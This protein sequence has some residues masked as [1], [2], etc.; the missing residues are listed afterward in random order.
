[1]VTINREAGV[2]FTDLGSTMELAA[3]EAVPLTESQRAFLTEIG[4]TTEE[5]AELDRVIREQALGAERDLAAESA[6]AYLA[7]Q[8]QRAGTEDVTGATEEATSAIQA[9]IDALHEHQ[10]TLRAQTDPLFA[11]FDAT[12]DVAAAQQRVTDA[13]SKFGEGSP[14]HIQALSDLATESF[15][16]RDAQA[17]ARVA[18]DLTKDAFINQA[19][20]AGVA[21]DAAQQLADKLF[22]L[23]GLRL[24]P[25][26]LAVEL[27]DLRR[28]AGSQAGGPQEFQHGGRPPVGVASIVGEAG[29][30][31]FIPD[32]PGTIIPHGRTER[33]LNNSFAPT[34]NI[35][36]TGGGDPE[37]IGAA[38]ERALRRVADA[39]VVR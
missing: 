24:D 32:I 10:D 31:L 33:I 28:A 18:T 36:V 21:R 35:N 5:I 38:V 8:N 26:Q 27:R 30:E 12:N 16:L 20:Q 6:N 1:M 14:E 29:Q 23:E 9:N 15:D 17:E 37:R 2:S 19:I 11:L 3:G 13:I 22:A 39:R 34:V 4:L 25:I 7:F